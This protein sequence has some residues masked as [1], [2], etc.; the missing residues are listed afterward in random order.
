[1][2]WQQQLPQ[3]RERALPSGQLPR[4]QALGRTWRDE[5]EDVDRLAAAEHWFRS[6]PFFYSLEPGAVP[7]LDAFLFEKQIGFC[8]HYAGALAALM[9]AAEFPQGWS[10]DTRADV[11]S[12]LSVAGLTWISGRAMPMRGWR[13]G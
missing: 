3:P 1:M 8:G 10:V 4:L 2:E 5:P 12:S 9:R 7:D 11:W 6:Q 13:S